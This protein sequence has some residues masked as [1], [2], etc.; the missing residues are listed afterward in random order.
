ML[1]SLEIRNYRNLRHLTIEKLGRVNLLVGK[2]NTGK[3]SVLEAVAIF[4]SDRDEMTTI[5]SLLQ[6]RGEYQSINLSRSSSVL[7]SNLLSI[8]SLYTDYLPTFFS[9]Q[10]KGIYSGIYIGEIAQEENYQ[11]RN[12]QID[13]NK[14]YKTLNSDS[15]GRE[16]IEYIKAESEE[17]LEKRE[18]RFEVRLFR[19]N[20][21]QA[22]Y[23]L[24]SQIFFEGLM[25]ERINEPL[26]FQYV[27]AKNQT[28]QSI[29]SLYSRIALTKE[30]EVLN[31]LKIIEPRIED[32]RV[33][34]DGKPIVRLNLG[35]KRSLSSM[36]D[37]VGRVFSVVLSMVTCD[38]TYLLIDEFENGLHYSVQE[39]LWEIIF[40]LA[41]RLNIQVFA[42]THSS[43]TIRSFTAMLAKQKNPNEA[44]KAIRLQLHNDMIRA[45]DYS[46]EE[47]E[48]AVEYNIEVR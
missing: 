43:D 2:N 22:I 29:E 15:T 3:T 38:G 16:I 9:P 44:G 10:S 23:A 18:F 27:D 26:Q 1:R 21:R 36:G 7:E 4:A 37:G 32:F 8:S 48:T 14:A 45:V 25:P 30:D 13:F 24:N 33:V 41:E 17:D 35:Q 11:Q 5:K 46:P 47:L 6:R 34:E 31:A 40:D 19:N 28:Q 39:K 12:L 42:T 20:F